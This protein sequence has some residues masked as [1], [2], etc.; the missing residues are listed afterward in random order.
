MAGKHLYKVI[1]AAV[2]ITM[3]F[4]LTA[5]QIHGNQSIIGPEPE[6]LR[7]TIR[8]HDLQFTPAQVV[9]VGGIAYLNQSLPAAGFSVQNLQLHYLPASPDGQRLQ[10][11]LNGR[12]MKNHLYDWQFLPTAHYAN[13][14]TNSVF[15]LF[16]GL[17]ETGFMDTI[18]DQEGRIMNYH[19]DL[20]NTLMG[21]RMYEMDILILYSHSAEL[22]QEDGQ[23]LLGAGEIPPDVSRN[24]NAFNLFQDYWTDQINALDQKHRSWIVCDYLN[25]STFKPQGDSLSI[26]ATPYYYF[27]RFKKDRPDYDKTTATDSIEA[28]L[29]QEYSN[30]LASN[31]AL[32]VDDWI[33]DRILAMLHIYEDEYFKAF[34][35]TI[36]TILALPDDA[37]RRQELSLYTPLSLYEYMLVPVLVFMDAYQ[38]EHLEEISKDISS[39]TDLLRPINPAVWDN[40]LRFMQLASFFRY[41]R[42]S[43]PGVWE[44]WLAEIQHYDAFPEIQTPT[45]MYDQGNAVI[46]AAR[47]QR[48]A[49]PPRIET[50]PDQIRMRTREY[51]IDLNRIGADEDNSFDQ[52]TWQVEVFPAIGRAQMAPPALLN[53]SPRLKS[54]S[55]NR[56]LPPLLEKLSFEAITSRQ[57]SL[58]K[59][60]IE[61]T[62]D[63]QAHIDP[64]TH[65]CKLTF[66]KAG[67]VEAA[68]KVRFR[69]TDPNGYSD[70]ASVKIVLDLGTGLDEMA[71]QPLTFKL[72]SNFPN[73]F[74]SGT[75]LPMILPEKSQVTLTVFDVLGKEVFR[76][77]MR[78]MA[79]GSQVVHWDGCDLNGMVLSTG[80][81]YAV[82]VAEGSGYRCREMRKMV[83]IR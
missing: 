52:L 59:F 68:Y 45:A 21:L 62:V 35:G 13:S 29:D 23:Y 14:E 25:N 1:V 43:H 75:Q 40:N 7:N 65:R 74:N 36:E 44:A 82:V 64:T 12:E 53:Q 83:L 8:L 33:M 18:L 50:L 2:L 47:T 69:V 15:T 51:V 54:L 4:V 10:I 48:G 20:F 28:A 22:P 66:T 58:A 67:P 27:W 26:T 39:R 17:V 55:K 73:P 70:T 37:A 56:N 16:G 41:C 49:R 9:E 5:W 72:G 81:Y 79:P 24:G 19:P 42:S 34:T 80:V 31:P 76:S 32:S 6:P 38:V 60:G 11:I 30:A 57:R 71:E 63:L 46:D 78:D 77:E 61:E 3:L